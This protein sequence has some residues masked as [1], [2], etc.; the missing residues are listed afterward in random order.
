LNA[1]R[2]S[3]APANVGLVNGA[4]I[5]WPKSYAAPFSGI[6]I[7]LIGFPLNAA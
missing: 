1:I 3:T 2:Q 5:D 7:A 4:N 6:S